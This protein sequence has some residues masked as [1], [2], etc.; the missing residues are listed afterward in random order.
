MMGLALKRAEESV[1]MG[2][3]PVGAVL[4][5]ADGCI[6]AS[7]GNNTI[8]SCDPTGHAEIRVLRMA[9]EKMK[10]YRMPETTLYVTLEPCLMCASAMVHARIKRVVFGASDPKTGAIVSRYKI[11]SDNLLNH[12]F[13]ITAGILAEECGRILL[14]FF[15]KRR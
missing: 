15:Q 13:S 4:V 3:V 8:S 1:A 10:N 9:A 2:E 14:D 11:G 6:L 5:A 7:A 12:T